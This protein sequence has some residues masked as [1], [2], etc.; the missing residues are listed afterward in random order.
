VSEESIDIEIKSE[1][2]EIPKVDSFSHNSPPR[3]MNI[4]EEKKEVLKVMQVNKPD[5][6]LTYEEDKKEKSVI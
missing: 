4:W 1:I 5:I 6:P 2:S 3:E